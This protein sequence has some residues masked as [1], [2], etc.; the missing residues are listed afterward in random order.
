MLCE[1]CK[2]R[3]ATVK[4]VEVINGVKTEHN[5][6]TQC[7]AHADLGQFS[8]LFEGEFPLGKLLSGLLGTQET[9]EEDEKYSGVVCP[10]CGTTYEEFVKDSRF[11]CPD[12]Y[13]VFDLLIHDKIRQ[14]QGNVRHTGKHPKF[15]KIKADPFHLTSSGQPVEGI[16]ANAVTGAEGQDANVASTGEDPVNI[17]ELSKEEKIRLMETRLKDAVRREEYEEAA[18]LRDEIRAL[19]EERQNG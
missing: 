12:C 5:L 4:Y 3:E 2:K 9:E 15:Q 19:K 18:K 16:A 8:A 7:A 14:L 1:H 11:G 6:C 10:T 17:P 13:S